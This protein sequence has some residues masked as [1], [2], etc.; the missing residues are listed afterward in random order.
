MVKYLPFIFILLILSGCASKKFTKKGDKFEDAGLYE[1]A[2]EYYYQAVKKKDS[3]LDAKIGLRKNGQLLLDQKLSDFNNAY[4]QG[5]YKKAVYDFIR[6]E[7]YYYKVKAVGVNL[8]FPEK[9]REYYQEAKEEYLTVKYSE[10]IDKLNREDFAS[11]QKVFKE[12]MDI[13]PNYK[14]A[15]DQFMVAKFEPMY[16]EAIQWLENDLYRK[17]YYQFESI[18]AV[19]GQYKQAF[20]LKDEAREKATIRIVVSDFSNASYN[21]REVSNSLNSKIRGK[22][23]STNNPFLKIIDP[24]TLDVNL[25]DNGIVNMQAANLAGINAV[26][27]GRVEKISEIAGKLNKTQQKGYLKEIRKVKNEAGEEVEKAFY[28]K[29]EYFEYN[30]QNN[31]NLDVSFKLV[32]TE[33][34]EVLVS[35]LLTMGNSDF[36]HYATFEGDYKK[37]VPGHWKSKNGNSPEDVIKDNVSD[38]RNL[39]NLMEAKR[40]AKSPSTLL[41]ELITETT[42]GITSKVENYNPEE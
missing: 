20:I 11:A 26:L 3:N 40:T 27:T 1:D 24:Q 9:N 2:A 13:D 41:V 16:R 32:S 19:T 10:G 30:V 42:D 15:K 4:V 39:R 7:D 14:D 18:L 37:L 38:V 23:S 28:S 25:Y 36:A 17:A 21:Y 5:D 35:D 8:E 33:N 12:I 22:L 31:A 6:A 34:N 29:T